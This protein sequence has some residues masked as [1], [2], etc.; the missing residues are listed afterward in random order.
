MRTSQRGMSLI[1]VLIAVLILGIG[2]LGIAAMQAASLRNSQSS[3]QQSTAVIQA[4]AI[5]DAMRANVAAAQGGAYNLAMAGAPC[6]APAAGATIASKDLNDWI[7][8][9]QSAIAANACGS[10]TCG[11]T[12]CS[13]TVQWSDNL[14]GTPNTVTVASL[15]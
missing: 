14:S 13:V 4:N 7:T 11:A 2:V 1:E 12:S 10:V 6:A 5:M 15:L 8:S 3:L 9:L